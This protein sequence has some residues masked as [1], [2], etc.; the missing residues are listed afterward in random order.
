MITFAE[1]V[2]FESDNFL[3]PGLFPLLMGFLYLWGV[4][5]DLE[6]KRVVLVVPQA[7]SVVQQQ[8]PIGAET[9]AVEELLTLPIAGLEFGPHGI[10]NVILGFLGDP[11][12]ILI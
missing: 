12:E 10:V 2:L 6:T 4:H 1:L 3:V 5:E 9:I 8:E 7:E 11:C